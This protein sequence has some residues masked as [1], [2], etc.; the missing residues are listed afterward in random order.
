MGAV[1]PC[2]IFLE[3]LKGCVAQFLKAWPAQPASGRPRARVIISFGE[4]GQAGPRHNL[5]GRIRQGGWPRHT[6]PFGHLGRDWPRHTF[7]LKIYK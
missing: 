6:F 3:F 2:H 5:F 4:P 1:G 7:F